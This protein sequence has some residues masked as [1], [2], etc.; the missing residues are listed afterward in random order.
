MDR[1]SFLKQGSQ[2]A[3]A[4]GAIPGLAQ[5]PA[6]H[7][8]DVYARTPSISLDGAWAIAK[9]EHNVG[10]DQGWIR[11][12]VGGA[13]TARVPGILQENFPLYHGLVWYWKQV[14]IE[15]NAHAAGRYLLR[16]GA[17]DY[18]CDVWVNGAAVGSHEGGETDFT[19]DITGSVHP[20]QQNMI[21]VRVL[22][23]SNTPID[24][25]VLGNI[26]HSNTELAY[27]SGS[28]FDSGGLTKTV[29]VL[30]TPAV[31]VEDLYVRADWKTGSVHVEATLRNTLERQVSAAVEVSVAPAARGQTLATVTVTKALAPGRTVVT[32]EAQ[33]ESHILWELDAP[34]LYRTDMRVHGSGWQGLHE[35]S[36]RFGFRD[37]RVENG[38][39]RLNGKRIFLRG[40]HTGNHCPV[41]NFVP[42]AST[43]DLLR[44]DVLYAKASG[45]NTIRA[46]S[47]P[48]EPYQLDLC[49]E[50]G[51]MVYQEP[52]SSWLLKDSPR[53]KEYYQASLEN[54]VRRDRNHPCI[55]VWGLLNET[56]DSPTFRE[57]VS[58][59]KPLRALDPLRLV[60]LSSGRWDGQRGIGTVSNPGSGEW[61]FEW[62]QEASG[63]GESQ[64]PR[65]PDGVPN[66]ADIPAY[67]DKMGD[68][69]FYPADPTDRRVVDVMRAIGA[70]GNPVLL[71]EAGIGSNKN[72]IR[73]AHDYEQAGTRPDAGDFV[74]VKS[75]ADRFEADWKAWGFE[76][77]YAYPE[78]FLEASE[79]AMARH[80]EFVFHAVRSNPKLCGYMLTGMLDHG[81]S[82]EGLWTFWR[83]F[84]PGIMEVLQ[85]GWSPVRWCLFAEPSHIYSGQSMEIEAVLTNEDRL[86]PGNYEA[87]FRI[88]GPKGEAWKHASTFTVERAATGTDGPLA[89][90]V[91]KETVAVDGP[92]GAYKLIPSSPR[93]ASPPPAS[94]EFYLSER[95][96]LPGLSQAV[97]CW[98]I[99]PAVRTWLQTHGITAQSLSDPAASKREIIL[100]GDVSAETNALSQWR[101]LASRMARGAQLFFLSPAAFKRESN[102][103]GWVPLEKKGG[104]D[105]FRDWLYHRECVAKAHPIFNGLQA[106]ALLNWYYYGPMIPHYRFHDQEAADEV[107]AAG[108]ATGYT[109]PGGYSSGTLLTSYT[110]AAGRF[111][112]NAF[113]ILDHV[114]R[115]PVAD[116]MLLNMIQHAASAITEPLKELPSD[117]EERL[118]K[119]GYA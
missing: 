47:G 45:F 57:A 59:L 70:T 4:L 81:F 58:C 68:V 106:N 39:F 114:D 35:S 48:L 34:Y 101:E 87:S 105:I 119:I 3:V 74:F 60:M 99:A 8:A 41:G 93:G 91:M 7:A 27:H 88:W 100:V 16:F 1:R 6:A 69:H 96:D 98:G 52:Q 108:F 17:V 36:A 86:L 73:E 77:V 28:G 112:V 65:L 30:L 12:P 14:Q 11:G 67:D 66:S 20:G 64:N 80:R 79:I 61:Q 15:K 116:R 75:I 115:H 72:V 95:S 25:I 54:M 46:L 109:N 19:F 29:E 56:K 5:A 13:E 23:P 18:R 82:G 50:L 33:I 92:A 111:Y 51:M 85:D 103:T 62:G 42:P 40:T 55:A 38:Y 110:F 97:T 49:D 84:K 22:N 2:A 113:P 53:M 102:A 117:F 71:S 24:G 104:A 63:A 9:D 76:S 37:F 10:R 94:W 44:L 43:P 90:P 118:K 83:H 26:A 31:L 21:A 78:C 107:I 32:A 89:I